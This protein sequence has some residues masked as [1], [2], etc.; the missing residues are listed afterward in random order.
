MHD[1]GSAKGVGLTGRQ[2]LILILFGATFA[3]MIWGVSSQGWWMAEMSALFVASTIVIGI[4]GWMGEKPMTEA[5]VSGARDLL[6]VALVIGLARG[7]VVIMDKGMITDTILHTFEGWITGMSDVAFVNALFGVE[8]LL[9]FL[10]PSTSGLAVLSMPILAPLS[11]FAG[12]QRDLAVTACQTAVGITNLVTPT[13][14]VVVGGLAIGRVPYNR[15][16][17]FIWPLLAMLTILSMV[18]LSLAVLL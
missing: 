1:H 7:I 8:G 5:F 18:A 13:Y 17:Q 14:A 2:T 9:S 12:V 4:V 11:D 6:G 16:L 10:V 3:V 15:W